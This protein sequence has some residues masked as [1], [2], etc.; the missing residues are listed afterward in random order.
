[1]RLILLCQY[2]Q[3]SLQFVLARD[4]TQQKIFTPLLAGIE[5]GEGKAHGA[6]F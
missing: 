5:M 1:M 3:K 4:E 6:A 2:I